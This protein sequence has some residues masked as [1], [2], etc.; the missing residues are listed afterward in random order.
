MHTGSFMTYTWTAAMLRKATGIAQDKNVMHKQ[1]TSG[2]TKL[3]SK[4]RGGY[5][6]VQEAIKEITTAQMKPECV[7]SKGWKTLR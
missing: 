4:P 1:G 5:R 3:S 7:P 6:S 2:T